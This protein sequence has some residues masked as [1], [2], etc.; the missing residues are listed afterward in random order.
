MWAGVGLDF[1]SPGVKISVPTCGVVM[2]GG[3]LVAVELPHSG[4]GYA[5]IFAHSET[6]HFY[7]EQIVAWHF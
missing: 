7:H 2:T 1:H 6:L 4:H 3:V 5:T